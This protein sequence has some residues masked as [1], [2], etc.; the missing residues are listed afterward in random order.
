MPESTQVRRPDWVQGLDIIGD[1][2]GMADKLE[3]LLQRLGYQPNSAGVW[4][5]PQRQAVFIGDLIDNGLQTRATL[6]TV[7]AMVDHGFAWVVMGNHE[8]N[9]V[10]WDMT[11]SQTGAPLRA[12]TDTNL[13]HHQAFLDSMPD[14]D[15]RRRWLAWFKTLPLYLDF[16]DVRCIHACW[17]PPSLAVVAK[18]LN[19]D[20][21]LRA[22]AWE[23]AFNEEHEA[24]QAVENLLKGIEIDLPSGLSF[25][26]HKGKQRFSSRILWWLER[27]DKLADMVHIPSPRR[28][29]AV[30]Q[31]LQQ[32][33]APQALLEDSC[34]RGDCPVFFGHYWLSLPTQI[35]HA[36]AACTDYSAGKAGPLVAYRWSGEAQLNNSN[37]V[38]S[39]DPLT[40]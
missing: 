23:D 37:W 19:A 33:P 21:S 11:H 22:D 38:T 18:Y 29:Q 16:G 28:N 14:L 15:E 2:H 1:V 32:L 39:Q 27:A 13:A 24:F 20:Q 36:K 30:M 26:D 9:A 31:A 34:Y 4:R 35:L 25:Y 6:T 3:A 40:S 10:A 7:K 8:L 5:H 17:H 12:H